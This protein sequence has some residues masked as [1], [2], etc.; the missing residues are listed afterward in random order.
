SDYTRIEFVRG[1]LSAVYPTSL[2]ELQ[3]MKVTILKDVADIMSIFNINSEWYKNHTQFVKF[4]ALHALS[5]FF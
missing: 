1:Y 3:K 5:T 2:E 4:C